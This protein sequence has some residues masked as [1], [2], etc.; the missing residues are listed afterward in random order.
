MY[1]KVLKVPKSIHKY[2]NVAKH[3]QKYQKFPNVSLIYTKS[4]QKVSLKYLKII[5]IVPQK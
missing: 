3:T 5:A 1:P 2:P 4:V